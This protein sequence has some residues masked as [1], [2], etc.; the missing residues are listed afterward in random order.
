MSDINAKPAYNSISAM[1]R[2]P[3]EQ[4]LQKLSA[5]YTQLEFRWPSK[6]EG[7]MNAP[8]PFWNSKYTTVNTLCGQIAQITGPVAFHWNDD[9]NLFASP[10]CLYFRVR[11]VCR[12]LCLNLTVALTVKNNRYLCCC[13]SATLLSVFVAW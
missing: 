9:A 8:L 6:G 12:M 3:A 7:G 13:A 2:E 10:F 5:L 11:H 1:A 4:H